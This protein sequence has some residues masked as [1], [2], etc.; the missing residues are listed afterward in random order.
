MKYIGETMLQGC[1]IRM[2]STND[3]LYPAMEYKGCIRLE[4]RTAIIDHEDRLWL[5]ECRDVVSGGSV[6]ECFQKGYVNGFVLPMN[7]MCPA[8]KYVAGVESYHDI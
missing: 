7:F 3:S 4:V 6:T 8:N 1:S 2:D 5:W